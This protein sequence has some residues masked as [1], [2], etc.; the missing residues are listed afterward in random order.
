MQKTP[1]IPKEKEYQAEKVLGIVSQL[2]E[3]ISD[4]WSTLHGKFLQMMDQ[5]STN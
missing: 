1:Q 2:H 3:V 4:R 5:E